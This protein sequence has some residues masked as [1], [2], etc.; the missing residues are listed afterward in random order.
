M[1]KLT[2][3]RGNV[4]LNL[5]AP[6]RQRDGAFVFC[7]IAESAVQ[8]PCSRPQPIHATRDPDGIAVDVVDGC[9]LAASL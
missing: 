3:V 8:L 5:H 9:G 6:S 4:G 2:A 7:V 1:E